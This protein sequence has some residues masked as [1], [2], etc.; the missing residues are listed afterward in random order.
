M[1]PRA[2]KLDQI[3]ADAVD[4]ARAAAAEVA[5]DPVGEYLG[6]VAEA[7]RVVT[8]R[9]AAGHRGYRGWQWV[10]T[11]A[12]AA[13]ARRATV[14]EV[15]VLPGPQA[16]VA[17]SWVPWAERTQVDDLDPGMVAPTADNDPRLEP[18]FTGGDHRADDEPAE[19]SQLRAVVA[20][21]GLGRQRVLSPYGRELAATRWHDGVG[22]PEDA[23]TRQAPG[24]C[25]TC[26]YFIR[27]SGSLGTVFGACANGQTPFDAQVVSVDHGCGGHSDVVAETRAAERP[28]MVW[29][30]IIEPDEIFT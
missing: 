21:L 1:P 16:L 30:T 12:R 23:M 7:D 11:L 29:D 2:P 19:A 6:C 13:R 18:G 5:L 20:E 9:F 10:V 15:V 26:G 17:P 3:C 25:V 28:P 27:L 24:V 8:H 14:N 22:G 4:L